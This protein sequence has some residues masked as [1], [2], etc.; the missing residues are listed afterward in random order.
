MM[1]NPSGPEHY[2]RLAHIA[3]SLQ[4]TLRK[5]CAGTAC[6]SWLRCCPVGEPFCCDAPFRGSKA[7]DMDSYEWR[8]AIAESDR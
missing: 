6:A 2:I 4:Y 3:R 8:L 1:G 5:T 7:F